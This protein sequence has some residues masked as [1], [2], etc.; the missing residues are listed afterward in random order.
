[1]QP[2]VPLRK[3]DPKYV[4]TAVA[5]RVEGKV[6]LSAIIRKDGHVD[7]VVLLRHLDSAAGPRP[8]KRRW[9]S[10]FSS[11]RAATACPSTW[12]RSSKSLST[13]PPNLHR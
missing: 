13:W 4:A 11:P 7:S 5:E 2:P 8:P 9:P 12:T 6:R 10:G 3:V 1:M